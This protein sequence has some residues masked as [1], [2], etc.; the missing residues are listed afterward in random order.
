MQ[1]DPSTKEEKGQIG[2][3]RK[4]MLMGMYKNYG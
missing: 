1:K 2:K 4:D 3:G